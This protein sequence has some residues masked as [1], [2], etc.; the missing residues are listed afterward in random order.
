VK[1][2]SQYD[3]KSKKSHYLS[4]FFTPL[5]Y[6]QEFWKI[7]K[8]FKS[9]RIYRDFFILDGIYGKKIRDNTTQKT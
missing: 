5:R 1:V 9:S 3:R 4:F 2:C 6:F 7:P 8:K